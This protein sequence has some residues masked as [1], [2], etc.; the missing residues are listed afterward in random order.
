MTQSSFS[1]DCTSI[2]RVMQFQLSGML[3]N[4]FFIVFAGVSVG[5]LA[6]LA[7]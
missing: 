6:A 5:K 7:C 2:S 3:L 1:Y 4:D